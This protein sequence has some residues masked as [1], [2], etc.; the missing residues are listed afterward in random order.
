MLTGGYEVVGPWP[1]LVRGDGS[2]ALDLA[3]T[4]GQ[5]ELSIPAALASVDKSEVSM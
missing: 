5:P 2:S 3:G 1:W 4:V